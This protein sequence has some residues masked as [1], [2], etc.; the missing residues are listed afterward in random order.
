MVDDVD[1]AVPGGTAPGGSTPV[2]PTGNSGLP[3][4]HLVTGKPPPGNVVGVTEVPGAE[5]PLR[6]LLLE[7]LEELPLTTGVVPL[8][9]TKMPLKF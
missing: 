8:G 2:T 6:E 9:V 5:L 4:L 1:P 7:L 3:H